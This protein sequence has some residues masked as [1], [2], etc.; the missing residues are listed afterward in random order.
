MKWYICSLPFSKKIIILSC[1]TVITIPII[2]TMESTT[3]IVTGTPIISIKT[4]NKTIHEHE[5]IKQNV[6]L[7]QN[8]KLR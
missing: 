6:I 5:M 4:K 1:F 8:L 3:A 2:P 7:K